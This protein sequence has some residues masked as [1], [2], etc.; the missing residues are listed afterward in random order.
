MIPEWQEI[1]QHPFNPAPRAD[2]ARRTGP[3][4]I[5]RNTKSNEL[6]FIEFKWD[7][8]H[9]AFS[10]G[11]KQIRRYLSKYP[12]YKKE[13]VRGGYVAIMN[14]DTRSRDVFF[15]LRRVDTAKP[16]P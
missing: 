3:D 2:P 13:K 15:W 10:T 6:H 16:G 1:A 8:G 9:D 4:S 11:S 14:W 5:G 12:E 7:Q